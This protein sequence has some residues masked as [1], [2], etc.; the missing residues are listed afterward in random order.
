MRDVTSLDCYI[1]GLYYYYDKIIST[2]GVCDGAGFDLL[3]DFKIKLDEF[4]LTRGK[5]DFDWLCQAHDSF[6]EEGC[7]KRLLCQREIEDYFDCIS[8]LM[9][10]LKRHYGTK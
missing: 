5:P 8:E 3:S 4:N 10:R 9:M 1:S 7:L 6:Y 2:S